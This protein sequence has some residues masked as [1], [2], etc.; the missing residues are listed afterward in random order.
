MKFSTPKKHVLQNKLIPNYWLSTWGTPIVF[1]TVGLLLIAPLPLGS[2]HQKGSLRS[3]CNPCRLETSW[4]VYVGGEQGSA[5]QGPVLF[6]SHAC[7]VMFVCLCV[8]CITG[9][10]IHGDDP[11]KQRSRFLVGHFMKGAVTHLHYVS[12]CQEMQEVS[13]RRLLKFPM[14]SQFYLL[15]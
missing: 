9:K 8:V 15:K 1:T 2:P 10:L 12:S 4:A 3:S 14:A 5:G 11:F 7:L 6:T 13:L